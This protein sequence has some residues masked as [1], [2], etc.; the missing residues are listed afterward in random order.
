[1]VGAVGDAGDA[2][3]S[4]RL[5]ERIAVEQDLLLAAGARHAAEQRMLPA[6]DEAA[7][8]GESAVRSR[9][10]GVVLLDTA[11]HLG[12]QLRL[13]L[14]GVGHDG[15][16]VGVLGVEIGPDLGIEQ[17]GIAHHRLPVVGAKPGVIVNPLD[18]VIAR[19]RR[20]AKGARST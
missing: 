4:V 10:A 18:A 14:F 6:N 17:S 5:G 20:T 19:G 3:I 13:E 9:H 11:L 16:R 1:M 2:E 8:I 15:L 7:V 12:E